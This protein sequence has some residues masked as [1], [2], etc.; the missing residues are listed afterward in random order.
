MVAFCSSV[1]GLFLTTAHLHH[2]REASL[3][4]FLPPAAKAAHL[5]GLGEKAALDPGVRGGWVNPSKEGAN[6]HD[7][8]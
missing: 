4:F 8:D 2:L 5:Q 6:V 3:D 7:V 1:R